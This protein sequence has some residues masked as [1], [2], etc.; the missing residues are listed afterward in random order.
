LRIFLAGLLT[1]LPLAA[2]AA[3][4]VFASRLLVDWLGPGSYVGR[5]LIPLGGGGGGSEIVAYGIG[6]GLLL[7]MIF[8]VGLLVEKGLQRG[9][10]AAVNALVSRIPV[11]RTVYETLHRF[12]DLVSRRDGSPMKTMQPV[13]CHFGGEGGVSVLGLLSTTEPVMVGQTPCLAVILP[14]A[15]VPVGGALLYVPVAWIKPATLSMEALTSIYVSMGVSSPQY[16]PPS[17][18]PG[19]DED[20]FRTQ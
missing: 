16:L 14:T 8:V 19:Q 4:L 5:L 18:P 9:A 2:T 3:L 17:P 7:G 6:L 11:I 15:P 10:V 20:T 13:W 1:L 12:V